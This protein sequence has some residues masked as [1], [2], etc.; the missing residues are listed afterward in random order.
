[1]DDKL[2]F[3][4]ITKL[5]NIKQWQIIELMNVYDYCKPHD[6]GVYSTNYNEWKVLCM[7]GTSQQGRACSVLI[8]SYKNEIRNKCYKKPKI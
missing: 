8:L 1:M 3:D 7:L 5:K 6:K 2:L 4:Y